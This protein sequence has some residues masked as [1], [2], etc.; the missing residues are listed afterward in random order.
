MLLYF[1]LLCVCNLF[2]LFFRNSNHHI[3]DFRFL[4]SFSNDLFLTFHLWHLPL[5][6]NTGIIKLVHIDSTVCM[7]GSYLI[8]MEY[9]N[10]LWFSSYVFIFPYITIHFLLFFF[11][12]LLSLKQHSCFISSLIFF[13]VFRICF[14]Y[15]CWN[16]KDND[17]SAV[18]HIFF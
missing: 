16:Y 14:P 10:S 1:L 6:T 15:T 18:P 12:S 8:D 9:F 13:L 3:L 7:D 4:S 2:G 17:L 5:N 11:F